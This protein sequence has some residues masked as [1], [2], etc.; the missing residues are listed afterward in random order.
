MHLPV[1]NNE[2]DVTPIALG[3]LVHH[4]I[5]T[6]LTDQE[7]DSRTVIIEN[8]H[9]ADLPKGIKYDINRGISR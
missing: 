6:E 3:S 2:A 1:Q 7:V 9:I 4:I 5:G 8:I